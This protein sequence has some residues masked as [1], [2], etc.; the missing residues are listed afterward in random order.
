M[1]LVRGGTSEDPVLTK[2]SPAQEE[3][4]R[5]PPQTAKTKTELKKYFIYSF[6]GVSK[7]KIKRYAEQMKHTFLAILIVTMLLSCNNKDT[8][9]SS[10]TEG[11]LGKDAS[12]ALGMDVGENMKTNITELS[13]NVEEFTRGIKDVLSN[14][15][16]RFTMEEAHQIFNEAFRAFSERLETESRQAEIDFLA[17]NSKKPGV[18]I[19]NSGLQYIVLG[20]GSGPKP[21]SESLVQIHFEGSL[22]DGT[23]LGSTYS[24]GEPILI[25]LGGIIPGWAEGLQL[26][27]LGSKYRFYIPSDLGYGPQGEPPQ[28]PPYSTL[29]FEVELLDIDQQGLNLQS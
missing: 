2:G 28:V 6:I 27:S 21:S 25:H 3:K 9:G 10:S 11:T 18:T 4:A 17:E 29:I 19:T 13:P 12:Y 15:K 22:S 5:K 8:I 14:S 20:E 26:M 23:V 16:T 24:N 1:R 7:S